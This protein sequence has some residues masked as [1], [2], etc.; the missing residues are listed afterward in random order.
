MRNP[1]NRVSSLGISPY[2]YNTSNELNSTPSATYT[3]DNNGST[4]TKT[5][6]TGT[7][8]YTWD[9]ENRGCPILCKAKG[10][11]FML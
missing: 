4:S 10:W 1:G 11:I 2:G 3:Y 5:D 7:S 9:F 8:S 6:S